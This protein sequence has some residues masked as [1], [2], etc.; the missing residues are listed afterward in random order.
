MFKL[1]KIA[2]C[3][4]K[5]ITLHYTMCTRIALAVYNNNHQPF[6]FASDLSVVLW[7]LL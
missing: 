4:N 7:C 1:T 5:T 6:N 2:R 3:A